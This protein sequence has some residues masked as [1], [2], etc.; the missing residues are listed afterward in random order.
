MRASQTRANLEERIADKE[1][2]NREPELV[3][4]DGQVLV[5]REFR[6][7]NVNAIEERNN[8]EKQD[9][10]KNP[11]LQLPNRSRFDRDR[12]SCLF[13]AHNHLSLR[14]TR[15]GRRAFFGTQTERLAKQAGPLLS[16]RHGFHS[17]PT[18]DRNRRSSTGARGGAT[19]ETSR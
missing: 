19:L 12:R 14:L 9:E 7:R 8:V 13:P 17:S 6:K 15:L 3:A 2:P 10:G 4:G 1:N 11:D 16:F 5:H 18:A